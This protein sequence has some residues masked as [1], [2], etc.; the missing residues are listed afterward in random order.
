MR[1]IAAHQ[2]EAPLDDVIYDKSIATMRSTLDTACAIEADAVIFHVGSHLGAGFDAGLARVVAAL[3]QILERAK[4]D[5][6]L[7]MENGSI[8]AAQE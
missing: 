5:T 8:Y 1:K 7:C 3:Q 4:G 6:W 2:L